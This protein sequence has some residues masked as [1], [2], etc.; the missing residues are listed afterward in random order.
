M[1]WNI[2]GLD[3]KKINKSTEWSTSVKTNEVVFGLD[4]K[5]KQF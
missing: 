3:S 2:K 1:L 5:L 4:I